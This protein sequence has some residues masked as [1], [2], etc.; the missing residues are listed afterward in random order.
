[1]VTA[2]QYLA[3]TL[4]TGP[5]GV[6]GVC[7]SLLCCGRCIIGNSKAGEGRGGGMTGVMTSS[8]SLVTC[9]TNAWKGMTVHIVIYCLFLDILLAT[10]QAGW[11]NE[12]VTLD[13]L[14]GENLSKLHCVSSFDWLIRRIITSHWATPGW[15]GSFS[16]TIYFNFSWAACLLL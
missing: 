8:G 7:R 5:V 3:S 9:D 16:T 15:W 6:V 1:M 14:L 13:L 12:T 4:L 2:R 10:L 11:V